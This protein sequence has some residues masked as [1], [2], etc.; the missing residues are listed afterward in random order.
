MF[1]KKLLTGVMVASMLLTG[2][3]AAQTM[4]EPNAVYASS[5][6]SGADFDGI[7]VAIKDGKAEIGG[8]DISKSQDDAWNTIL[9][10]FQA[11]VMGISG[12]GT[13]C[14]VL[15][16]IMNFIKLGAAST[17]P[18]EVAKIK[19]ALLYSGL[20]AAGLGS[21]TFIVGLFYGILG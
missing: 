17:N 1:I 21:V 9:G 12:I 5:T 15:F 7:S 8:T 13:I 19:T 18:S 2:F 10:K 11:V 16:F 6:S 14:M 20:A 3:V 4:I